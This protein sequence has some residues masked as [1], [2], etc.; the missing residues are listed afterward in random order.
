[1]NKLTKSVLGVLVAAP[2]L[3]SVMAT[4]GNASTG[5]SIE[6]ARAGSAEAMAASCPANAVCLWTGTRFRGDKI[7]VRKDGSA[8]WN[9]RPGY[10]F[11][12]KSL[13]TGRNRG[14]AA[15]RTKKD[16]RGTPSASY[17]KNVKVRSL[18]GRYGFQMKSIR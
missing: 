4:P 11:P 12:V 10:I 15:M 17:A 6:L 7:T 18:G 16:C 13:I 5:P 8:C 9:Y 2:V 1:M 3:T 14:I